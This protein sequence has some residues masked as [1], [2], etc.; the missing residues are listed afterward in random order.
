SGF[1]GRMHLSWHSSRA[2]WPIFRL[3]ALHP[4]LQLSAGSAT[5]WQDQDNDRARLVVDRGSVRRGGAGAARA[6]ALSR[7]VGPALVVAFVCSRRL[8][9]AALRDCADYVY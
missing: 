2:V 7:L 8:L 3:D 5:Q 6:G 4:S 9:V 1:E